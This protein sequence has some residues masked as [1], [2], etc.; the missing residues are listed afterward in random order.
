M[1]LTVLK[2]NDEADD[3]ERDKQYNE[4]I[5]KI[6][7]C[8]NSQTKVT[9]AD[10][11]SNHK[12]HS[13]METLSQSAKNFAPP[14]N[15][16]PFPTVWFYER[17]RGK[18]E[19]EQMKL[20]PS[21]RDKYVK[22]YPKS[23]VVKKEQL[24]KCM[25]IMDGFP[26]L[27][28]DISSKMMNHIAPTIDNICEN[29][30]EQIND[31]FFKKSIASIIIY[32][33]VEKIVGKQPWYPKG[34]NRAQI[35]PY[36]IAK[37]LSS[38]YGNKTIDYDLIWKGQCLYPSFVYEVEAVALLT[39]KF[40]NDSAGVIVREYAR[41]KETWLKFKNIPYEI[42]D[43]FCEDLKKLSLEKNEEK[44]AKKE[45]KFNNDIDA[46]VDVFKL[47]S[48]YWLNF[49]KKVEYEKVVSFAD[50]LFIKSIAVIISRNSL[51]SSAQ[52]KKVITIF[53]AA[54]DAG[55]IFE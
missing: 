10:F 15:G 36:T 25:I 4:M 49:Y 41:H 33:S 35:V 12:F 2:S 26:Y 29:S 50:K 40:L 38:I 1:K 11:F 48:E 21:Q 44:Q 39:H 17:S 42:S 18:W 27:A 46:S 13:M 47:G 14:S 34:G 9:P 20:N 5:Q 6:S 23:Q 28:C 32:N 53:N 24:A 8:A 51:P 43:A 31:Y 37:L 16:D 52:A 55:I 19:Q 30:I 3:T 7:E 54:E 22:K 45:R